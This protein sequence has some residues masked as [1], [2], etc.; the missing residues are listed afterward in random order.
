MFFDL[1]IQKYLWSK[2][3]TGDGDTYT[4]KDV[5]WESPDFLIGTP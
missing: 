1:T 2:N 5:S 3:V 4:Q